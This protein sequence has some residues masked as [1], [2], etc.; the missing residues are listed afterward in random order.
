M[1]RTAWIS[2]CVPLLIG[3]GCGSSRI[4]KVDTEPNVPE[5]K[6]DISID[7]PVREVEPNTPS[8]P[9]TFTLS[10]SL[11]VG[12]VV[13]RG[14][15]GDPNTLANGTY[16][17]TVEPGWAGTVTPEREGFLFLPASRTYMPFT[18][19]ILH[20]IYI[21]QPIPADSPVLGQETSDSGS[22]TLTGIIELNGKPIEGVTLRTISSNSTS[23][24]DA[25]GVF[26]MPVPEGWTGTLRLNAPEPTAPAPEKESLEEEP[27][28]VFEIQVKMVDTVLDP[29]ASAPAVLPETTE[30]P[31]EPYI[32]LGTSSLSSEAANELGHDLKVM[33]RLLSEQ[34][35]GTSL[36]KRDPNAEPRAIYVPGDGVLFSIC[37]DWPLTDQSP[38]PNAVDQAPQW[39]KA[40]EYIYDQDLPIDV[41]EKLHHM[42]TQA[43]IQKMTH[44]L[45]HASN[46]RHLEK[47]NSITLHIWGP[48]P[49]QK[50]MI[51]APKNVIED[52]AEA[53]LTDEAFEEQVN[54]KFH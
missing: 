2:L 29:N 28:M 11:G 24:T 50:L 12:S 42:K 3:L 13:L 10:G 54:M 23:V 37:L 36:V 27:L 45:K 48:S 38:K 32:T 8:D 39:Q 4:E 20:E 33:C 21:P 41:L 9:V 15:P 14:L 6:P 18:Q 47:E 7:E 17:I 52:Y 5:E 43:F 19:D 16:D 44:C 49:S 35:F 46:I 30:S 53:A 40:S 25:N 1:N 26:F 22:Q 51:R 34:A 31:E